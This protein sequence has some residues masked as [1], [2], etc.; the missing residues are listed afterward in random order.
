MDVAAKE[1][2]VRGR[3]VIARIHDAIIIDKR[4]GVD[5]KYEV[6]HAMRAAT[7]NDYWHL[8]TKELLP[9]ER[10]YSLDKHEIDAQ[11]ERIRLE[12][13]HAKSQA[14]KGFLTRVMEWVG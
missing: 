9:Y 13:V 1:T 5:S 7:S 11:R 2:E 14:V 3:R 6:E 10:P 12:E 4:L 8:A